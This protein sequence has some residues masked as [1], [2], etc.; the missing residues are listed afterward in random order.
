MGGA[1]LCIV[2]CAHLGNGTGHRTATLVAPLLLTSGM[3]LCFTVMGQSQWGMFV[4]MCDSAHSWRLYSATSLGYQ[5]ARTM[6]C[7]LLQSHYPDTDPTNYY[8][9]NAERWARK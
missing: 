9:N 4:L 3:K 7:Y 8:S 5:A 6:I 1:Y 2:A